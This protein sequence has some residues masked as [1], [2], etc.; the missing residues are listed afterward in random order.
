MQP[1]RNATLKALDKLGLALTNPGHIWSD[2][3]REAYESAV[4]ELSR[5]EIDS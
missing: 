5:T 2:S 4:R 1:T 3:E